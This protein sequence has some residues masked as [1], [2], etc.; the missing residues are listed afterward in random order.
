MIVSLG[1][2]SLGKH[3]LPPDETVN[4][5]KHV[6]SQCSAL[7]FAGLMTIGRYGYDLSEGP[8]PDFQV[9]QISRV[10]S[11]P[12]ILLVYLLLNIHYILKNKGSLLE[13]L[14][15]WRTFNIYR[16]MELFFSKPK[17][18]SF[19]A[20]LQKLPLEA[21]F[22]KSVPFKSFGSEW[23]FLCLFNVFYAH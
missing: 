18:G 11:W 12:R 8:N 1:L 5:V 23:F 13:S 21:L 16:T 22:L 4:M 6:V 3:G 9:R 2:V 20:L 15:P 14:V 10:T 7:D 17:I 19:M